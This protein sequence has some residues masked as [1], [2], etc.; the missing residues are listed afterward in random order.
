ML[1]LFKKDK[2]GLKKPQKLDMSVKIDSNVVELTTWQMLQVFFIKKLIL[3]KS[4][5]EEYFKLVEENK[6][7]KK[8]NHHEPEDQKTIPVY[9]IAV[10]LDGKVVEVIRAQ[11]KLADIFLAKPDYVLFN[12]AETLVKIDGEYREGKFY[13]ESGKELTRDTATTEAV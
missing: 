13:D 10:I 4:G 8:H 9:N 3:G 6:E 12:S 7:K 2:D 1:S 5:A 11:E